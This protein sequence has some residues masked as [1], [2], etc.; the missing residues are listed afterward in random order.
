M[1]VDWVHATYPDLLIYAIPNGGH[2]SEGF[3]TKLKAE[4]LLKGMPDL[5]IPELNLWIEMKRKKG[6]VVSQYQKDVIARLKAIG[7]TAV[8]CYGF[9]EAKKVLSK[10]CLQA[11]KRPAKAT[12][13][14]PAE[15]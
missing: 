9:E 6:G 13:E 15:D 2:P 7:H 1:L 12:S 10:A 4:G 8:V 11:G 3:R 5:H 14:K